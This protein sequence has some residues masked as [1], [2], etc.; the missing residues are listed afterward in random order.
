MLVARKLVKPFDW[1]DLETIINDSLNYPDDVNK[2]FMSVDADYLKNE[3]RRLQLWDTLEERLSGDERKMLNELR[4][5]IHS[6]ET[7]KLQGWFQL[8]FAAA[9][10]LFGEQPRL[11]SLRGSKKGRKVAQGRRP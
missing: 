9:V 5:L 3:N 7:T 8:G 2:L 1:G 10:R 4:D 11:R 6:Q